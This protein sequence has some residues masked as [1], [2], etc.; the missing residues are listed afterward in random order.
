MGWN[1]YD[2]PSAP[3]EPVAFDSIE[4]FDC[5]D[6]GETFDEAHIVD[7]LDYSE[8]VGRPLLKP[9]EVGQGSIYCCLRCALGR[10]KKGV[11][12]TMPPTEQKEIA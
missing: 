9:A 8:E 7:L 1:T 5:V 12:L 11:V 2:Y 6:C 4:T 3:P 10:T